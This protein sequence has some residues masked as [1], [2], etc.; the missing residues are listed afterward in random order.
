MIISC[1]TI[2]GQL[3]YKTKGLSIL[4]EQS[5][6]QTVVHS[7]DLGVVLQ[8]VRAEFS[9]D[10]RLLEPTEGGLVGDQVVVVDPDGAAAVLAAGRPLLLQVI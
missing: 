9:A 6:A 8:R 3:E 2:S 1:G 10:S 4:R 5:V 7:L